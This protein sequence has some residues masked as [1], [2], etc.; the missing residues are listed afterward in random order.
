MKMINL[1][2][3]DLDLWFIFIYVLYIDKDEGVMVYLSF[4]IVLL[5]FL[6]FGLC[7]FCV[8]NFLVGSYLVIKLSFYV[9]FL[10]KE[11]VFRCIIM[12]NILYMLRVFYLI[13][14]IYVFF[15]GKKD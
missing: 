14:F 7:E 4:Y 15:V 13:C 1:G 3:G 10:I 9:S 11:N 12:W 2:S 8:V 6:V 5:W